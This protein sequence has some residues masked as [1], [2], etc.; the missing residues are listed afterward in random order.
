[1]DRLFSYNLVSVWGEYMEDLYFVL[2]IIHR[3]LPTSTYLDKN[4]NMYV[5]VF[6]LLVQNRT[7]MVEYQ[8]SLDHITK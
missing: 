5:N 8:C 4:Y 6:K 1:M 2:S 3:V 7:K